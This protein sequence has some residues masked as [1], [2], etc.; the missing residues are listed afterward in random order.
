MTRG[1]LGQVAMEELVARGGQADRVWI[2]SLMDRAIQVGYDE[3]YSQIDRKL[4]PII[5]HL[6]KGGETW[7]ELLDM[8]CH[9]PTVE[10]LQ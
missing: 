3:V 1:E 9:M 10:A 5:A 8:E 2:A 7:P 6:A 4:G